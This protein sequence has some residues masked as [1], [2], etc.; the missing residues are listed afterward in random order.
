MPSRIKPGKLAIFTAFAVSLYVLETFFPK[1]IP[2]FR[3][4]F[5][6]A[7]VLALLI[8][9]GILSAFLVS[10]GK[11]LIGC[12]FTGTLFTPSLLFSFT[13]GM[14]SLLMMTGLYFSGIFGII[15]TSMGGAGAHS[16]AQ[17]LLS[18]LL[19]TG[20]PSFSYLYPVFLAFSSITGTITGVI[21]WKITERS[22]RWH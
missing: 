18:S 3:W 16:L 19:F 1:P 11:T 13:G 6:N 17:V 10:I 8:E 4:G 2:W 9:E 22:E 15:G 14:A 7:F 20:R 5:S 21:A 12:L